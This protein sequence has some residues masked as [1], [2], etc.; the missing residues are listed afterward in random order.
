MTRKKIDPDVVPSYYIFYPQMRLDII[1]F[2]S[3]VL[4]VCSFFLLV[5]S[6]S[7]VCYVCIAFF[8]IITS[9]MINLIRPCAF[10]SRLVVLVPTLLRIRDEPIQVI[11]SFLAS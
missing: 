6:L 10:G 8:D 2:F 9:T 4:F 3:L 1:I 11:S 7:L 5:L